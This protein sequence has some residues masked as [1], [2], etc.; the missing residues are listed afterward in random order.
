ML[1]PDTLAMKSIT[2][3]LGYDDPMIPLLPKSE[4]A[5]IKLEMMVRAQHQQVRDFIRS[6]MRLSQW[7]DMGRFR[8]KPVV[9]DL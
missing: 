7:L 2:V 9:A 3:D 6:I 1:Q 8:V 5:V 4:E